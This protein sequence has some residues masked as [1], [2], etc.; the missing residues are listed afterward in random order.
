[1]EMRYINN[2]KIRQELEQYK[3]NQFKDNI[4][5][6][7]RLLVLRNKKA[8]I[9]GYKNYSD[10]KSKYHM[11]KNSENIKDFLNDL[12]NKLDYRFEKE[13][14]TI[15]KLK[16]KVTNDTVINSWDVDYYIVKWKKK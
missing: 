12:I 5:N 2:D 4:E 11:A 13:M 10:F 7:A 8:K 3:N 1:M 6:I 15:K 14:E 16:R 9:L